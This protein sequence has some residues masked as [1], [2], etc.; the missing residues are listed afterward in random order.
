[1]GSLSFDCQVCY[2]STDTSCIPIYSPYYINSFS[3]AWKGCVPSAPG[4]SREKRELTQQ[5]FWDKRDTKLHGS[6]NEANCVSEQKKPTIWHEP[7]HEPKTVFY[8]LVSVISI[9]VEMFLS[10]TWKHTFRNFFSEVVA[11]SSLT[12]S[13]YNSYKSVYTWRFSPFPVAELSRSRRMVTASEISIVLHIIRRP[14][15]ILNCCITHSKYF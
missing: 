15:S 12:Y 6:K 7:S 9:S 2:Q 11:I 1:M 4:L 5:K 8:S 14:N 10:C 13:E 3:I